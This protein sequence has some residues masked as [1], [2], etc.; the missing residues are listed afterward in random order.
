MPRTRALLTVAGVAALVVTTA[1]LA[2]AEPAENRSYSQLVPLVDL[3]PNADVYDYAPSDLDVTPDGAVYLT[4]PGQPQ[5]YTVAADGTVGTVPGTWLEPGEVLENYGPNATAIKVAGDGTGYVLTESTVR[6]ITPDGT[7]SVVAGGGGESF[8]GDEDGGD[9]GPA[10]SADLY[11]LAD[12]ALDA[13]GNQY[14][15]DQQ[16][17]RIRRIDPNGVI[18]T[19]AGGGSS[20]EAEGVPA[21]EVALR[22][23]HAVAVDPAGN[24]YLRDEQSRILK[25]SPAGTISTVLGKRGPGFSGD[26]GPATAG[27]LGEVR[28]TDNGGGLDVDADGNLYLADTPNAVVRRIDTKG[29]LT[30]LGPLVGTDI[31]V[32]PNGD[33]YQVAGDE[34]VVLRKETRIE[35][36]RVDRTTPGW[37]NRA[38]GTVLRVAGTG[39]SPAYVSTDTLNI[40][41]WVAAGP[42]G[43]AYL[44]D[45]RSDQVYLVTANGR[46]E[47]FAGTGDRGRSGDGGPA[48]RARLH[49]PTAVAVGPDGTVYIADQGNHRIRKVTPDGVITTHAKADAISLA[50][51]GKGG[52]KGTLYYATDRGIAEIDSAGRKTVI[53]GDGEGRPDEHSGKPATEIAIGGD[54]AI[55]AADDGT[56]YFAVDSPSGIYRV[57]P[58]GTLSTLAVQGSGA[59]EPNGEADEYTGAENISLAVGPTGTLYF[60]DREDNQVRALQP[61]GT[62]TVVAQVPDPTHV[63]VAADGTLL[64]T[65]PDRGALHRI[66]PDGSVRTDAGLIAGKTDRD[67]GP[68]A[69]RPISSVQHLQVQP[70]GALAITMIGGVLQV[71]GEGILG[72]FEDFQIPDDYSHGVRGDLLAFGPDG[73]VYAKT[74]TAGV[75][76]RFPDGTRQPLIGAYDP[77][78]GRSRTGVAALTQH[79][80]LAGAA[81]TTR[82]D[83]YVT[84]GRTLYRLDE[85]G[86]LVETTTFEKD[87]RGLIAA[88]D[89]MLYVIV[90]DRVLRVDGRHRVTTVAGGGSFDDYQENGDGGPATEADLRSPRALAV[91]RSGY[92][93]IGTDDGIRR[94]RP[95][96]TIGTLPIPHRSYGSYD[97]VEVLAVDR[98]GTVYYAPFFH[99]QISAVVRADDVELSTDD[100]FPW[101]AVLWG[102]V[103]LAVLGAAGWWLLRRRAKQQ[104]DQP[105]ATVHSGV[106]ASTDDS[107]DDSGSD[108][109]ADSTTEPA[110]ES[111][112]DT[113]PEPDQS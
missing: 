102:V 38:P 56:V 82:G 13:A 84:E 16:N 97:P 103:G 3:D 78:S 86:A 25:I 29:V 10:T 61:S 92:L 1:P 24:V 46:R 33:V 43:T 83:L 57:A 60:T 81:V 42:D 89:G 31:A 73:S 63:A 52:G 104:A 27:Q 77:A 62:A 28:E 76:R 87:A 111:S 4:Q 59:F 35:S 32:A 36:S 14:V 100:L 30:T 95:D 47:P 6:R 19:F 80:Q 90:G 26:G 107:T 106:E 88:P 96:G 2:M 39:R 64:V 17:D 11:G 74:D 99:D 112:T 79:P 108:D 22:G 68:A 21:T 75:E 98:H 58:N 101:S 7:D 91:S 49:H 70:S 85:D 12:L 94:V 93:Y 72:P 48:S 105:D 44:S 15:A 71:D 34:V 69:E 54:V 40:G 45:P 110:T 41:A 55:A 50:V 8:Y 53:A 51:S 23:P 18:T 9:G 5:A 20:D 66:A 113:E 65:G 109:D 67:L 37:T